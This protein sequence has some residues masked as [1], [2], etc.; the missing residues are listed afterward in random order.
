MNDEA[1]LEGR[2]DGRGDVDPTIPAAT[3][4]GGRAQTSWDPIDIAA[5]FAAGLTVDPPALIRRTD[6]AAMV[7]ERRVNEIHGEPESG[8]GWIAALGTAEVVRSS[9]HALYVDFE[10]TFPM[11]AERLMTMGVEEEQIRE[12]LTYIRPL[13]PLGSRETRASLERVLEMS[14]RLAIL[15]G[16][17][18][19]LELQ[20]LRSGDVDDIATFFRLVPARLAETGAA[21]FLSDHVTKDRG[22]RRYAIGSGHKLALVRGASYQ[23]DPQHPMGRGRRGTSRLVIAKDTP[24][25]VRQHASGDGEHF[26]L[27]VV[28]D[29]ESGITV[30]RIEP[31]GAGAVGEDGGKQTPSEASILRVLDGEAHPL[32]RRQVVDRIVSWGIWP[33]GISDK[34]FGRT[35]KLLL[36]AGKISREAGDSGRAHRWWRTDVPAEYEAEEPG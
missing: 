27:L 17:N 26:G 29:T 9:A 16:L 8:K 22:N 18:N 21:T 32:E 6:G 5:A 36:D 30:V 11:L 24:G 19:A 12:Y 20:S 23:L 33:P 28:D 2:L 1:A 34:T 13:E 35:T 4:N 3:D 15:D 14:Y 25:W 7:Y 31:P 10:D